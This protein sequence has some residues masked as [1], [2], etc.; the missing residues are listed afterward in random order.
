MMKDTA[1]CFRYYL[2]KP[3]RENQIGEDAF[4]KM[5]FNNWKKTLEKFREYIGVVNA[6]HNDVRV[7]FQIFQNQR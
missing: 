7:Q 1:F 4:I 2:F 5:G 3:S 6:A